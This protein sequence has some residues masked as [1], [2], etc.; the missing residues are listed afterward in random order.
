MSQV[1]TAVHTDGAASGNNYPKIPSPTPVSA[2][3]PTEHYTAAA[4]ALP[5]GLSSSDVAYIKSLMG[6]L[7]SQKMEEILLKTGVPIPVHLGPTLD[8]NG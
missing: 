7:P 3:K 1:I 6:S 5:S 8:T 2:A 4:A